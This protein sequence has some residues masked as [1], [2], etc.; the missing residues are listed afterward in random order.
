MLR[1]FT[2]DEHRPQGCNILAQEGRWTIWKLRVFEEPG[3]FGC[4]LDIKKPLP[5]QQRPFVEYTFLAVASLLRK[6]AFE[7]SFACRV[8]R[9]HRL[10]VRSAQMPSGNLTEDI[11]KIRRQG[12]IATFVKLIASQSRPLTINLPAVNTIAK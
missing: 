6:K 1:L 7:L 10:Q 9:K 5:V 4:F 2:S 12:K 8:S 3:G 11:A